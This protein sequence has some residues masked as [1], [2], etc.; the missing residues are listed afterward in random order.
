MALTE[1][2][3]RA[4]PAHAREYGAL[5]ELE[6]R[7]AALVA[8][9]EA[10]LPALKLSAGEFV[11]HLAARLPPSSHP[12]RTLEAVEAEDL[13]LAFG[14]ALGHAGA[15]AAL[16]QTHLPSVARA[17]KGLDV[18]GTL[19]EEV[20]QL[21]RERLLMGRPDGPPRIAGYAGQGP[22]KAWLKAAAIRHALNLKR[23]GQRE[24]PVEA[25]RLA[26][27]PLAAPNPEL[28]LIRRRHKE[29]FSEAFAAAL[30]TLDPRER[31]L[32]KLNTLDGLPLDQIAPLYKVDKST[33]SRWIAHARE[34]LQEETRAHLLRSLKLNSGE[35]ES[36]MRVAQS[37][38]SLSLSRLLED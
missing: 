1:R 8:R 37:E 23:P 16:E 18:S 32:L 24:E 21:L 36:V 12:A 19:G 6:A 34:Q 29:H 5:D 31:T 3:V 13:Y 7:L 14:C 33:I 35:L 38:L 10:A 11:A 26:A 28:E 15:L 20:Q 9:G 22:L 4:L 25:D 17:V 2:F 30:A 27:M